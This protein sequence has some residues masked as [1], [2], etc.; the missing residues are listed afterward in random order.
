MDKRLKTLKR[1]KLL[2]LT[3]PFRS[4]ITS[5][6]TANGQTRP[7]RYL[8]ERIV[9][10]FLAY[11]SRTKTGATINQ[12][13]RETRLH[14]K[15]VNKTLVN[16]EDRIHSHD[17]RWFSNEPPEGFVAT[18]DGL[19]GDH[20]SD[21]CQYMMFFPPCNEA[22]IQS[23]NSQRR[24][25]VKHAVVFSL[26][27]SFTKRVNPSSRLSM[28]LVSKL[29]DISRK[30]V[31]SIFG[32]L[33]ELGM[34]QY[35]KQGIRLSLRDEHLTLFQKREKST[36]EVKTGTSPADI[37]KSKYELKG[38]PFDDYRRVCQPLFPQCHAERAIAISRQLR[39][40]LSD[41]ENQ[42]R[43]AKG[44]SD[45]NVKAG[46]C[47]YPNLGKFFVNRLQKMLDER[48][49]IEREEED[50][51]RRQEYLNS[52]EYQQKMAE[53]EQQARADPLDVYHQVKPESITDRVLLSDSPMGNRQQAEKI[54]RKV[55]LHCRDFMA[56]KSL[57]TQKEVDARNDLRR[58]V[59]KNALSRFNGCYGT[60]TLASQEQLEEAIDAVLS[61]IDG[62]GPLFQRETA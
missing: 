14:K 47:A 10:S 20:W 43:I 29:S 40:D 55:A 13:V 37:P 34:I 41:F 7:K 2:T 21:R 8:N 35:E 50:E 36:Q 31:S 15:T 6:R 32:D 11:Q 24:F 25:G 49:R 28:E 39:F 48:E 16:L 38:D 54:I 18:V 45:D 57:P 12:I 44:L 56:K 1:F 26:I 51:R 22:S 30:T 3:E 23:P 62:I 5:T 53:R 9:F 42:L 60:E 19:D 61:E 52:P 59:L 46:K 58:H 33:L 4:A 17:G 27:V